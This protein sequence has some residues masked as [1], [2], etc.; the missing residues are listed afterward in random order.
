MRKA[1]GSERKAV[2]GSQSRR[3][4]ERPRL[5]NASGA[6]GVGRAMLDRL[7]APVRIA[8]T[9]NRDQLNVTDMASTVSAYM[10]KNQSLWQDIKA[11]TATVKDVDASL[12]QIADA[13]KKQ[14]TPTTG[15]AQD[16]ASA[17]SRYE[18]QILLI[19][20]QLA[21]LGAATKNGELSAQADLT[22]SGLDKLAADEL[23]ATGE[24]ISELAGAN[25]A[26][27][28]DYGIEQDDVTEL[29]NQTKAFGKVKTEPRQAVV[30]RKKQTDALPALI[31]T[32]RSILRQRLDKQMTTFKRSNAEFYA[33][34]VAARVIVD[35]G[36][37]AKK[38]AP[39]PTPAPT[40]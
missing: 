26:A 28:A 18:D 35:R 5:G 34:Y 36:G 24:R 1:L 8:S 20:D 30:E 2:G 14:K 33:G 31:A 23:I 37:A 39:A 32:L 7:R 15:A 17:R 27:L 29:D 40:K 11:I 4:N 3:Y 22:L 19:A 16:K 10:A 12:A 21:A 6:L 25:L 9:M 13:D 38:P